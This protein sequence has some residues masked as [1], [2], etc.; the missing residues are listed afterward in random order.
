MSAL[1][2]P[3]PKSTDFGERNANN[4]DIA[5]RKAS[6]FYTPCGR[7]EVTLSSEARARERTSEAEFLYLT[8]YHFSVFCL[9]G[10]F[11]CNI[12]SNALA[13]VSN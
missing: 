1:R 13:T 2:A 6:F 10:G 5:S 7:F 12:K 8:K 11:S 4:A 9:L 3:T